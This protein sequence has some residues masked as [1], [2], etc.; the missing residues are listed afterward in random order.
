MQGAAPPT[1]DQLSEAIAGADT[2]HDP[3][4][5]LDL[6]QLYRTVSERLPADRIV[7]TDAGRSRATM[8]A[9]VDDRDAR[10]WIDS[11][12]WGSIGLGL[13]FTIGAAAAAPDRRVVLFSGDVGSMMSSHDLDAMRLNDLDLTIIVRNDQQ[14]GAELKYLGGDGVVIHDLSELR[15]EHLDRP[16]LFLIDARIDPDVDWRTALDAATI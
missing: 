7:V 11:Q 9:L 10:R 3:A 14:Y 5:G 15:D 8:A 12:G 1:F 6:R 16:G 2:G 4:R 13:G